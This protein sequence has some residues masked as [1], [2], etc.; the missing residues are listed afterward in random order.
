M[1]VRRIGA[2]LAIAACAVVLAACGSMPAGAAATLGND[3]ITEA[4]LNALVQEVL[5]AQGQAPDTSDPAVV[6]TTLGRM[7]TTRLVDELAAREGIVITQ[8]LIDE[9]RL[10]YEAQAGGEDAFNQAVAQQG[11]APSQID[12]L[13]QLNLQAQ[14]LGI[15]LLPQ[16]SAE[17][18]GQAVFAAVGA[19]SN[20]LG[21]EVS[22]RYGTWDANSA[23]IG[24]ALDDVATLP[25]AG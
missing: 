25:T 11:L 23:S 2:A 14:E 4:E 6:S 1:S 7:V 20:E 18:Q 24:P 8:G 22:P 10:Q 17:Q 12:D 15:A 19:L 16:G 13:I 5:A 21:V 9:T 3:R